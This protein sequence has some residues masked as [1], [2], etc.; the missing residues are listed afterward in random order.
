MEEFNPY[1]APEAPLAVEPEASD[2]VLADRGTRFVAQL[3]D[4]LILL[5]PAGVVMVGVALGLPRLL[6][7]GAT[8]GWLA[9]LGLGA[10]Q[11][12]LILGIYLAINGKLLASHGQT[13]G[14]KA[15]GIKIV[16][17][18]GSLPT[19]T[20]SF[21]RRYA[22]F[23]GVSQIPILG[24]VFSLVDICF[25]FRESRRCLHDELAGTIVVK[26]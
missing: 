17:L 14:K 26:A 15:C 13:W 25:I 6:G 5:V 8:L 1:A 22:L 16:R 10:V 20:E 18:D 23:Q 11:F 4:G 9:L 3:L 19:L 12:V 2:L 21:W 24:G 7:P